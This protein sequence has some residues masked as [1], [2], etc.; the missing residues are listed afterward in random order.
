MWG[1][2]VASGKAPLATDNLARNPRPELNRTVVRSSQSGGFWSPLKNNN[3][4]QHFCPCLAARV[5]LSTQL[6]AWRSDARKE[7]T[8]D[9]SEHRRKGDIAAKETDAV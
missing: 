5:L 4:H 6:S 2:P 7:S 8:H 1:L 9:Q 3:E